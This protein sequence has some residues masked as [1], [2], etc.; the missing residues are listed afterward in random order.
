MEDLLAQIGLT[1]N[2]LMQMVILAVI[3]LVGLVLAR[4]ALRL[5]AA[6]LRIGCF[7]VLMIITAVFILNLLN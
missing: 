5:T 6:L 1:P 3:L 4:I 7:I 2:E